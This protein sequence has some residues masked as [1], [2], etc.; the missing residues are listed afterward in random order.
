MKVVYNI[1]PVLYQMGYWMRLVANWTDPDKMPPDM[2]IFI[3]HFYCIYI[4]NLDQYEKMNRL[5]PA[6]VTT[7]GSKA[8]KKLYT[9]E[10]K[11]GRKYRKE[12]SIAKAHGFV[13]R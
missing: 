1:K 7:N 8:V 2:N 10:I 6:Y 5:I 3:Y 9:W 12:S 13:K 11:A 4:T